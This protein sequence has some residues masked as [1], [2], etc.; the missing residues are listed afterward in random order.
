MLSSYGIIKKNIYIQLYTHNKNDT[1]SFLPPGLP[2][3]FAL[4]HNICNNIVLVI[5]SRVCAYASVYTRPWLHMFFDLDGGDWPPPLFCQLRV[6]THNYIAGYVCCVCPPSS[7]S[8][9]PPPPVRSKNIVSIVPVM[10]LQQCF[11]SEKKSSSR[12]TM[13]YSSHV[14]TRYFYDMRVRVRA[15][16]RVW[17]CT[18]YVLS[19]FTRSVVKALFLFRFLLFYLH[20]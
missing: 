10:S 19:W 13:R 6:N 9:P 7:L 15:T 4:Q 1:S 11:P 12:N 5:I 18:I 17:A 2:S 14:L 20:R 3:A 8:S 16:V